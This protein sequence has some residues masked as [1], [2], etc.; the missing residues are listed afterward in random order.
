MTKKPPAKSSKAWNPG[1]HL[2]L[3][4]VLEQRL[5]DSHVADKLERDDDARFSQGSNVNRSSKPTNQKAFSR[6]KKG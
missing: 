6:Q 2:K 4:K 1:D 3:D 5:P